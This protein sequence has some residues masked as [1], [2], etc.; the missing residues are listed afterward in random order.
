MAQVGLAPK[1]FDLSDSTKAKNSVKWLNLKQWNNYNQSQLSLNYYNQNNIFNS[2]RYHPSSVMPSDPFKLDYRSGSYYV[3]RMV[4]DELNLIMNRPKDNAFV[5]V[6]GVAFIAAQL[7]SKYIF[8]QEKLKI[9]KENILNTLD[10]YIIMNELWKKSPQTTSE[11]YKIPG[12]KFKFTLKE[13]NL[14]MDNLI[15]NKLIKQKNLED[16]ELQFFP[17]ISKIEYDKLLKQINADT[18][19]T[20]KH[21]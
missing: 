21:K 18:N 15:D 8:V 3:P 17:A 20:E 2:K 12:L 7:A 6:L 16:K 9:S 5:P 14:K 19:A 4:R 10:D 1:L 13:L 11:L